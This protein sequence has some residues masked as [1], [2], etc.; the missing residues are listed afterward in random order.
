MGMIGELRAAF[1]YLPIYEK[2]NF[3]RLATRAPRLDRWSKCQRRRRKG[4][5]RAWFV[6]KGL[7]PYWRG[8]KISSW[9]LSAPCLC[10]PC[11]WAKTIVLVKILTSSMLVN[12]DFL[13][14]SQHSDST[15]WLPR[16]NE[17]TTLHCLMLPVNILTSST[18]RILRTTLSHATARCIF[19]QRTTH[20]YLLIMSICK[21]MCVCSGWNSHQRSTTMS[22][23]AILLNLSGQ[24]V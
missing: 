21:D 12:P 7:D 18:D 4:D 8:S 22:D 10:H 9:A 13:D 15:F 5:D 20:L 2:T 14:A 19:W 16:Q 3:F 11:T 23:F 6:N 17:S 1:A 24:R